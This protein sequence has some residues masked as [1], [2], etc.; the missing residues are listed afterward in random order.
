M[1]N[2]STTTNQTF[3]K[4]ESHTCF[5]L[6]FSSSKIQQ[7]PLKNRLYPTKK[8]LVTPLTIPIPISYS[9]SQIKT[10]FFLY[11][12]HG[13]NTHSNNSKEID[14]NSEN[15]LLKK[16]AKGGAQKKDVAV[17]IDKDKCSQ[18]ALKWAI[19]RLLSR[20][21]VVTLLHVKQKPSSSAAH[22]SKNNKKKKIIWNNEP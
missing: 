16:M 6:S 14:R 17:A 1:F 21:Q 22:S 3:C 7:K 4:Q 20:G 15:N 11:T 13:F 8:F 5:F 2:N 19:E 9:S 10:P 12:V 18:Y